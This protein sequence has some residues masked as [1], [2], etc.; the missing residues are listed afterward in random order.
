MV[1]RIAAQV[2]SE[3]LLSDRREQ[4]INAAITVF[5]NLG[6][7]VATTADIAKE[8]GLTQSNLYNYVSSKQDVL[9]LV[10]EHLVGAYNKIIDDIIAEHGDDPHVCLIEAVEAI[11]KVMGTHRHEVQLLYHETHAL[12]KRDRKAVLDSISGFIGRFESLI[13]EYEDRY[14]KLEIRSSRLAANL[15]SFVPAIVALR[16]W[17][18]ASAG[19]ARGIHAGIIKFILD[20]LGI[21]P[22]KD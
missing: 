1:R 10:C 16:S 4:I 22:L 9:L 15:L 13:K 5:H 2:Q 21:P 3:R 18:L 8:A 12:E 20:G 7:H 6:F 17:D 14:Q 11:L 19:G